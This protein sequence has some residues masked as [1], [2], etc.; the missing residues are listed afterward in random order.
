LPERAGYYLGA[1]ICEPAIAAHGLA[2]AVRAS[3]LEIAALGPAAAMT[4]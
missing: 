2:W 3:A 1:R 4:A